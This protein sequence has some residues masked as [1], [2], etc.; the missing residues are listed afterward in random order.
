MEKDLH[1][2]CY[3]I[4]PS[5]LNFCCCVHRYAKTSTFVGTTIGGSITVRICCCSIPPPTVKAVL[6]CRQIVPL[7]VSHLQNA[8]T[9]LSSV[10]LLSAFCA[11][12]FSIFFFDPKKIAIKILK[13][14]FLTME[15]VFLVSFFFLL[16]VGTKA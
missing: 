2:L 10:S 12:P 1:K 8:L 3:K 5:Y 9:L 6:P 4:L 14:C 13:Y 15:F 11:L 7:T 16:A